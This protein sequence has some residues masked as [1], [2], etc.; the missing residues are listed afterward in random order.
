MMLELR[1]T[2]DEMAA[3]EAKYCNDTGFNY[4]KFL[5]ELMPQDPQP[6]MYLERLKGLRQTNESRR[7]P[8][9]GP[10]TDL[11]ALLFKMK[12]KVLL[13]L[14]KESNVGFCKEGKQTFALT[15]PLLITT[16]RQ[17]L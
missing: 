17:E 9:L 16:G 4:M 11:E 6:F 7:L 3:L 8:E 5:A 15:F 2:Q 10:C 1:A 13:L 14:I 12:T